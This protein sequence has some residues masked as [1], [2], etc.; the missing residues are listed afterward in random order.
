MRRNNRLLKMRVKSKNERVIS[1]SSEIDYL[2]G[3]EWANLKW[4]ESEGERGSQI[5]N[6]DLTHKSTSSNGF[7]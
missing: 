3:N 1:G 6:P 5:S 2:N 7:A 4:R